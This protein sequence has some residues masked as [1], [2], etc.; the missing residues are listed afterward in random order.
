MKRLDFCEKMVPI[1]GVAGALVFAGQ[2]IDVT[3]PATGS[4]G[5]IGGGIL[6]AGLLGGV[7][8][9][10]SLAVVIIIQCLF[11]ADGGLIA[12]GCNIFNLGVIPCLIV[13]PLI[14]KPIVQKEF[15][16]KR[17][18]AASIISSIAAL[19]L[20]AFTL[21]LQTKFSGKTELP[22][23]DFAIV[24]QS[25][26]LAIGVIEGII[27]GAV[28]CFVLKFRPEIINSSKNDVTIQKYTPIRNFLV[29]FALLTLITG[30]I[31]SQFASSRPDGLEWSIF[32]TTGKENL[33]TESPFIKD[34]ESV[35]ES[36]AVM[37]DY[38][39]KNTE[40]DS[41]PGLSIAGIIGGILTFALAG[42][43][44]LIINIFK[45]K[46]SKGVVSGQ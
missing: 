12:L 14:F 46:K 34:A 37:P 21:V 6:L 25:I 11:F 45:R 29:I 33:D 26:H 42:I 15:T 7:P 28:L 9:F 22:F 27:T 44:A 18:S 38:N 1:M 3:I 43:S 8:A 19:Q 23:S 31:L 32:K 13:Y 5:H 24:M 39:T 35:Q 30:G 10:L 16:Q 4:S 17:I 20:G 36:I 41:G 2:M 40:N